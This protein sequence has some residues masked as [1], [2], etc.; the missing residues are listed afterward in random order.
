V[1]LRSLLVATLLPHSRQHEQRDRAVSDPAIA[2]AV[3]IPIASDKL[4]TPSPAKGMT[5]TKLNMNT[6]ETR[7]RK[8]RARAP[9]QSCCTVRS[10]WPGLTNSRS[11]DR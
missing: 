6:P 1:G 3:G 8:N 10:S 9:A 4:V 11:T 5:P 7:P 2:S